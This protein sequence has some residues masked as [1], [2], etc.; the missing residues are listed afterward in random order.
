M[1]II[2]DNLIVLPLII[3]LMGAI[4]LAFIR[5][6]RIARIGAVITSVLMSLSALLQ[7]L[8]L[9]DR[10]VSY[11]FGGFEIPYGI[12]HYLDWLNL[13]LV[14]TICIF[15]F[16]AI[17]FF[18]RYFIYHVE[19]SVVEGSQYLVYPLI[20]LLIFGFLGLALTRDLF[21]LYVFLEISSLSSYALLSLGHNRRSLVGAFEYLLLGTVGATLILISVG[22][23]FA[24]LGTLNMLDI[25]NKL[26]NMDISP[27][28]VIKSAIVI[29]LVGALLK[30]AFFPL[31][32]WMVKS[33][34]SASPIKLSFLASL[35]SLVG[36]YV[37][38]RFLLFT[39]NGHGLELTQM[40]AIRLVIQILGIAAVI[41][42][43]FSAL[44]QN[45]F[46]KI[47]L[48]SSVT[49]IGYMMI[50][51][52]LG[53]PEVLAI[54][55]LYM[56]SDALVKF[57]SFLALSVISHNYFSLELG[58][59]TGKKGESTCFDNFPV[60]S[61][62]LTICLISNAGLPLTIGFINKYNL[63]TLLLEYNNYY[64]LCPVILGSLL[65]MLYN[66]RAGSYLYFAAKNSRVKG[67]SEIQESWGCN[68]ALISLIAGNILLT[69]YSGEIINYLQN[70]FIGI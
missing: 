18:G 23:L 6:T 21:N 35:A 28:L 13:P 63:L 46:I 56:Y 44:F 61:L 39:T 55:M 40:K 19:T 43:S 15:I 17:S 65:G 24:E 42:G 62:V 33:Y 41:F 11:V 66:Y 10:D 59:N 67:L 69:I 52:S 30:I 31:H 8:L 5:N 4:I 37:I 70:N 51:L 64:L 1:N 38:L 50:L 68:L 47:L 36:F 12:E 3:S 54:L 53:G 22:L 49:H 2:I 34:S 45:K 25:A 27:N 9:Q 58:S 32:I 29:F 7:I 48:F 57:T 20:F 14:F 16:I 26:N 60:A